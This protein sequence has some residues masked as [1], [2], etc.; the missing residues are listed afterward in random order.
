MRTARP[1]QL[2]ETPPQALRSPT[3]AAA[4][5]LA[6]RWIAENGGTEPAASMVLQ[7]SRWEFA[8]IVEVRGA[9]GHLGWIG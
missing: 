2:V 3:A 1:L 5:E 7:L 4:G 8:W 9:L 6:D